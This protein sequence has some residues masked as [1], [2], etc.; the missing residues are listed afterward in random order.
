[1]FLLPTAHLP[2]CGQNNNRLRM[3]T[4][5]EASHRQL[6]F[7]HTRTKRLV[8]RSKSARH[9]FCDKLLALREV[10]DTWQHFVMG[11]AREQR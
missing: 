7:P 10:P 2:C 1:M 8:S 6:H 5:A 11:E 3:S 4:R 9:L